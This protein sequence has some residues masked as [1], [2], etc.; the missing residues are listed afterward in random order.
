MAREANH[1]GGLRL[2]GGPGFPDADFVID[3]HW[4][5]FV[6]GEN[7]ALPHRASGRN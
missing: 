2:Q 3:K 6:S 1:N 7:T 4:R 5:L